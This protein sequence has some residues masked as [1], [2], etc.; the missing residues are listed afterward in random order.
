V[1]DIVEMLAARR[2]HLIVEEIRRRGAVR[3]SELTELLGVSDMTVRRDLDVLAGSGLVDKVHGGATA[4][5][6]LSTD[7][8]G[9]EAKS[10]RQFAEK[11]AIAEAA[12]SLVEPGQAI[13]LSAGTT[14]WRLA[15]Y[16]AGVPDLTVVTNSMQVAIVLH[17]Q[18]RPD[19]TVVLIGGVR[20]PSDALVGPIAVTALRSM[21]VD[22][23]FMGVHGMAVD[24][25]FTTPNLLEAD[26]NKAMI[27][28][29]EQLAVVVDHTKWGVRGLSR[30]AE[31]GEAQVLVSDDGLGEDA[32]SVLGEHV[33]RL[34]VAQTAR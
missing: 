18:P 15:H 29:A 23:L 34:I 5:R 25:G 17:R 24:S 19:L 11:E 4:R 12:A 13:A 28:T 16:L 7:E 3:V 32:R 8:P 6:Q 33:G 31:L 21:H 30:M 1:L 20:T 14:T 27:E 10:R 2:Q 22:M 9:F 26:T